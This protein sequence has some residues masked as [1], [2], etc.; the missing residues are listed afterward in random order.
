MEHGM[1]AAE[2]MKRYDRQLRMENIGKEGQ[3]KLK[4]AYVFLAGA[5]GLGSPIS[6]F[7]AAAGIGRIRIVDEGIVEL[8]NLNRQILYGDVDL[9]KKKAVCAKNRL[10]KLNSH[11]EVEAISERIHKDNAEE[12]LGRC[13]IIVDAM[14]N[15]VTRYLLN[16]IAFKNGIPIMHGAVEE[17]YGQVTTIIPGKTSCLKCLLPESPAQQIW[18]IIG[19]TCGLIASIQAT[20][21]VKYILGIGDLLENRIL[22]LDGLHARMQEITLEGNPSCEICGNGE[23]IS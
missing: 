2:E 10:E 20:E 21:V 18:P 13:G 16:Q 12:L 4:Q 14:D 1:L 17:F 23:T 19:V 6:F 9:G 11:I 7:L 8:S 22:I 15:Y 5:G 3:A